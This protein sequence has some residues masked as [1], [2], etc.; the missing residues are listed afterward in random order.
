MV[1]G[2]QLFTRPPLEA[3]GPVEWL[4][5]LPA[6]RV[7][8]Q[9]MHKVAAAHDEYSFVTQAAK[10]LR[11]FVMELGRLRI[12]NAELDHRHVCFGEEMTEH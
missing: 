12:V 3:Y 1:A 11:N 2:E 7:G 6:P 8:V 4:D 9:V 10:S 5:L